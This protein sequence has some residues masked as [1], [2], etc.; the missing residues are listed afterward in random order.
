MKPEIDPLL[1]AGGAMSVLADSLFQVVD[2]ALTWLPWR[3]RRHMLG[4]NGQLL[5]DLLVHGGRK[6]FLE[7]ARGLGFQGKWTREESDSGGG[8]LNLARMLG[9]TWQKMKERQ[10]GVSSPYLPAPGWA[11]ILNT[12]WA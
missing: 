10:I 9:A 8:G 3:V 7:H 2:F 1:M 6:G 4:G 11:S 5:G 12:E